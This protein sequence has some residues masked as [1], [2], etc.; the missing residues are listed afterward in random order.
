MDGID[1]ASIKSNYARMGAR[2]I[3]K[4]LPGEDSRE[5][6]GPART[7]AQG[8]QRYQLENEAQIMLVAKLA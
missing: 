8:E 6:K 5:D 1:N 3:F 2:R 4:V 7:G